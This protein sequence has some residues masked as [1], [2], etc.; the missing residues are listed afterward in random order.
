MEH[1]CSFLRDVAWEDSLEWNRYLE[2]IL[3]HKEC[4]IVVQKQFEP[5]NKG[6]YLQDVDSGPTQKNFLVRV[7]A[8]P[9]V[10]PAG[11]PGNRED[12]EVDELRI[13]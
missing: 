9:L 3:Q 11:G 6:P 2:F 7:D 8:A 12:Q 13:D 4:E 5:Y 10:C 1:G